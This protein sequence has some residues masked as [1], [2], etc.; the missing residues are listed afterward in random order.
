MEADTP[1]TVVGN[2][3]AHAHQLQHQQQQHL[4]LHPQ[5]QQQQQQ[6]QQR[7]VGGSS[8]W[9][10]SLGGGG[11]QGRGSAQGAGHT[12]S[13]T[14]PGWPTARASQAHLHTPLAP[15]GHLGESWQGSRYRAPS[16]FRSYK[17]AMG[18]DNQG[19]NSS[20][21]SL[22]L[23][24]HDG[25]RLVTC[26]PLMMWKIES[27]RFNPVEPSIGRCW[28]V[29]QPQASKSH[30]I[31]A[32]SCTCTTSSPGLPA[33][34]HA[35]LNVGFPTLHVGSPGW[36]PTQRRGGAEGDGGGVPRSH[37]SQQG[38]GG[39][40]RE[41][42]GGCGLRGNVDVAACRADWLYLRWVRGVECGEGV[43]GAGG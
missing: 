33:L 19:L 8:Q 15:Q 9:D 28:A 3:P 13:P 36:P 5:Q 25:Q 27:S 18:G 16:S 22:S 1:S 35:L 29:S 30:S 12:P 26:G 32:N 11:V 42:R 21:F 43:E 10:G 24:G 39:G 6:Q 14:I 23:L 37:A 17:I 20:A 2:T 34:L 7:G 31:P 38:P 41:G 4:Q 40:S